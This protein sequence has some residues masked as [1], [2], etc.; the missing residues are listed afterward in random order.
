[1]FVENIYKF[2][3][4]KNGIKDRKGSRAKKQS[5]FKIFGKHWY[6]KNFF[7]QIMYGS[8]NTYIQRGHLPNRGGRD[9]G[10]LCT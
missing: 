9:A 1:M 7:F 3:D 5:N 2:F 6:I 4:L 8:G 10:I